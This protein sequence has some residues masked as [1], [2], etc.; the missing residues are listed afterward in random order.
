MLQPNEPRQPGLGKYLLSTY[1][2]PLREVFGELLLSKS[3]LD[4]GS[5][6]RPLI[7]GSIKDRPGDRD[8]QSVFLTLSSPSSGAK[9]TATQRKD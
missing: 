6:V 8:E 2:I 5:T 9:V 7:S 1:Y 3:A 4:L